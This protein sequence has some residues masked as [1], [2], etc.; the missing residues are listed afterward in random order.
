M[1]SLPLDEI[2]N[3]TEAD[4]ALADQIPEK[5]LRLFLLQNL[6]VHTNNQASDQQG[7]STR[8]R[9]NLAAIEQEQPSILSFPNY[10]TRFAQP[11]LFIRGENSDYVTSEHEGLIRQYFPASQFATISN[12]GHWLHAEQPALFL[13]KITEFLDENA[14]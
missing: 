7:N 13:K 2:K 4:R 3:R 8:W 10:T 9:L 5:S 12:A 6:I 11:T 14:L 1:K